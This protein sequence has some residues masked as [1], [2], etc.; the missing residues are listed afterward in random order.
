MSLPYTIWVMFILAL[1]A[2]FLTTRT[3]FGRHMYAIGGNIKAAN[4]F[5]QFFNTWYLNPL[6]GKNYPDEIIQSW[7]NNIICIID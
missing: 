5:D 1:I 2:V 7:K 4:L 3:K 6:Y